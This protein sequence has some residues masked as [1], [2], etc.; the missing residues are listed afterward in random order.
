MAGPAQRN[1]KV[2][3]LHRT[4][5]PRFAAL[6]FPRSGD[7]PG[8]R[9]EGP[10]LAHRRGYAQSSRGIHAAQPLPRHLRSAF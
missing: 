3:P 8:A 5:R 10:S 2:L 6:D 4:R 1:Q 7:V 9:R